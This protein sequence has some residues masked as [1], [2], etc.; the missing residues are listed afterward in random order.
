MYY[1]KHLLATIIIAL[2]ASVVVIADADDENKVVV[3]AGTDDESKPAKKPGQV[4]REDIYAHFNS[5]ADN[6][7]TVEDINLIFDVKDK[8]KDG[9]I[10]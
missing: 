4:T 7:T 10:T 2:S 3:I 5:L 9:Y 6:A 8:N 1:F